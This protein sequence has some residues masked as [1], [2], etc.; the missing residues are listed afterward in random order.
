M[1]G[2][3]LD[4]IDM[5][6]VRFSKKKSWEYE[7]L[8]AETFAYDNFWRT[9]LESAQNLKKNE[10][11][12]LDEDYTKFLASKIKK[13]IN[14][15][16]INEI[17]FIGS[18]GHTIF[19]EPSKGYTFQIG[20][21][22]K[23]A[24]YLNRSIICDFRTGDVMLGGQGAPFVPIGDLLLFKDHDICLNLGGF[25]NISIKSKNKIIAYDICAVNT[26]FNFLSKKIKLDYDDKGSNA[27]KGKL[28]KDLYNKLEDLKYYGYVPPKSLGIEWVK[29]KVFPL[30]ENFSRHPVTDLMHTYSLHVS[31]E[32]AKNLNQ[33]TSAMVTGGGAY[34]SFLIERIKKHTN[35]KL[36]LPGKLLIDYKEALI[37]AFLAVLKFRNE[38]NCLKTVTGAKRDHSSGRIFNPKIL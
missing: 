21:D 12:T 34:N 19:H 26:V 13:F 6:Y 11:K 18:H 28:I 35:T 1:S 9:K 5:V 4:G 29:A 22:N 15:K 37:F 23:L 14:E 3:S 7:I 31:K 38:V 8:Y 10:L 33:C 25:A 36:F 17:D 24:Y 2:T 32:I 20:N 27:R 16:S 30:F